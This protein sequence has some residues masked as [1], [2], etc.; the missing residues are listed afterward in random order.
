MVLNEYQ[1]EYEEMLEKLGWSNLGWAATKEQ[2]RLTH[3]HVKQLEAEGGTVLKWI[4]PEKARRATR[5]SNGMPL[6]IEGGTPRLART[7]KTAIHQMVHLWNSIPN[8]VVAMQSPPY[9]FRRWTP[10]KRNSLYPT[11]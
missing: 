5:L 8:I 9:S 3:K 11:E 2:L 1:L 7:K 6:K 10:Q 4:V